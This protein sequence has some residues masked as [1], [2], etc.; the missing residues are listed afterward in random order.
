MC[1]PLSSCV[2]SDNSLGQLAPCVPSRKCILNWKECFFFNLQVK[3]CLG[4]SIVAALVEGHKVILRKVNVANFKR[5]G[6][7]HTEGKVFFDKTFGQLV[8]PF[9]LSDKKKEDQSVSQCRPVCDKHPWQCTLQSPSW[10]FPI[11]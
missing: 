1:G 7:V 9:C 5:S 4:N 6:F 8:R 2:S 10:V 11:F 3:N